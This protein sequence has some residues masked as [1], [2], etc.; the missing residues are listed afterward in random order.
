M[1]TA[2]DQ[3]PYSPIN[4]RRPLRPNLPSSPQPP[5]IIYGV[6]EPHGF[7]ALTAPV[8]P[9]IPGKSKPTSP[10]LRSAIVVDNPE[11]VINVYGRRREYLRPE[12]TPEMIGRAFLSGILASAVIFLPFICIL[13]AKTLAP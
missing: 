13:L 12:I 11:E 6:F 3:N 8:S 7:P 4:Q 2:G 1:I 10:V 5:K 9:W